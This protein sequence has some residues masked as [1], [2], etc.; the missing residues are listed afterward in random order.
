MGGVYPQGSSIC[1]RRKKKKIRKRARGC[2]VKSFIQ[3]IRF[4]FTVYKDERERERDVRRDKGRERNAIN[5]REK[6]NAIN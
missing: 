1:N 4:I 2:Q 5:E 6:K 3:V